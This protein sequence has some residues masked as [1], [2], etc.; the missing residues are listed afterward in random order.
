MAIVEMG[1]RSVAVR[2]KYPEAGSNGVSHS[3]TRRASIC[4]AT[5][6]R[7]LVS[8]SMAPRATSISVSSCRATAWPLLGE[9][10][11]A[12]HGGDAQHVRALAAQHVGDAVA[13]A[14]AARGD[15]AGE[16]AEVE[17]VAQH[18]LHRHAERSA[19][20]DVARRDALE[21]LE[22]M[23]PAVPG[24]VL[25]VARDVVATDGGDGNGDCLAEAEAQRQL[26]EVGLDGAELLL[27][28]VDEIHLVDGEH[29]ALHADDVED[30]GVA[31]RLALHAVTCVDQHD[32]DVGVRGAGRHVARVLL[33]AGAVD[34]DEAARRGVEIAPG[35]VDGDALLALGDEAVEQQAE[36]GMRAAGRRIR[37]AIDRLALV[38]VE[39]GGVPQ[40]TADQRRLAVVDRSAR[41]K[42]QDAVEVLSGCGRQILAPDSRDRRHQK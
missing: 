10:E 26:A 16:A 6:G 31:A 25:G 37:R 40:Q 2:R 11:I 24:H 18:G 41:Q 32:G 19:R 8:E 14:D 36:I 35:D 3:H 29:D 9:L 13:D 33:V 1:A 42:V 5:V 20:S 34:D 38:V 15:G 23:R 27:R 39:V 17:A 12:A 7:L 4:V 28:P 22:Q 30:G 21:V